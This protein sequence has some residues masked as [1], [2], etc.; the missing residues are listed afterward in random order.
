VLAL[1]SASCL[2]SRLSFAAPVNVAGKCGGSVQQVSCSAL[3]GATD[4]ETGERAGQKCGRSRRCS[5]LPNQ[6]CQTL[7][8]RSLLPPLRLHSCLIYAAAP[9]LPSHALPPPS[10][11]LLLFPAVL[12]RTFGGSA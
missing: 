5:A 11:Y 4:D 12:K 10:P 1:R 9:L 3:A 8:T 7:R 2:T 6:Y